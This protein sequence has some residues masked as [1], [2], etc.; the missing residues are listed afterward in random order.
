[1][2]DHSENTLRAA[3]KSLRDIVAPALDPTDPLANEQLRL[4][5]EYLEF[6]RTRVYDIHARQRYEVG[7]QL[8]LAETILAD[9]KEVSD[10]APRLLGSAIETGR[11]SYED[12]DASTVD[13]RAAS[14]VLEGA[15]RGVIRE[16][17]DADA[18]VRARI[19][20][21]IVEGSEPLVELQSSWYLP[22][23][24]EPDPD[25]VLP[26]EEI[27]ARPTEVQ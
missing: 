24:F 27:L 26:L 14:S 18:A 23:G 13:L 6:L 15:I 11:R 20:L 1:M 12:A 10:Q 25:S 7:H 8:G 3:I 16:S 19:E 2:I 21:R 5:T 9:S 22:F 4:V 17:R